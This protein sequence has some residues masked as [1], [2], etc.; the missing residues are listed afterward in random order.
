MAIRSGRFRFEFTASVTEIAIVK[1]EKTTAF[2]RIFNS[3][4]T[5]FTVDTGKTTTPLE[6]TFSLD[7]TVKGEAKVT[8]NAGDQVEGIYEYLDNQVTGQSIRSGRFKI[9]DMSNAPHK[10]IDLAD[11]GNSQNAYYRIFN[12]GKEKFEVWEGKPTEPSSTMLF[13][14][15]KE[16]SYDFELTSKKDI[17]VK[18]VT[19]NE[20]IEG[21]YDFLGI[22]E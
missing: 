1:S 4:E 5:A 14:L 9:K 12:S 7:F 13:D 10:I 6:S 3:G 8:G 19:V 21:I 2:Y 15:G 11:K 16:Q 17:W 22:R 20:P 18:K